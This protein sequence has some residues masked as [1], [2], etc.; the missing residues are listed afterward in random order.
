VSRKVSPLP[1]VMATIAQ[2]GAEVRDIELMRSCKNL[3]LNIIIRCDAERVTELMREMSER[4]PTATIDFDIVSETMELNPTLTGRTQLALTLMS[5]DISTTAIGGIVRILSDR[6]FLLEST[7]RLDAGSALGCI[8]MVASTQ[9]VSDAGLA[10]LRR[11]LLAEGRLHGVDVGVQ[12]E[13]ALR[14]VKRL[15]VFDMDSTLIQHEVIDE[16]AGLV[17]VKDQ[18]S[19]IT[20]EA[21]EG[22]LDFA[23]SLKRRVALLRGVRADLLE[24]LATDLHLTP[25]AKELC[26]VLKTLGYTLAV[27]SGGFTTFTHH[28]KEALG[29]DFHFANTLEVDEN[30][31]LLTGRTTGHVVTSQ[32]KA[33][34]LLVLAQQLGIR[35]E[36]VIAI[37]DGANDLPMLG[38]AGLGIAFNAKEKV[39]EKATYH[40]NQNNLLRLLFFLGIHEAEAAEL[41]SA[42]QV[43]DDVL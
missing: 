26:R 33:D 43:P 16:I 29:L 20:Q 2:F 13:S 28:V 35:K 31:G 34:L 15:V 8:E 21:M 22:K 4:L 39:R 5:S 23:E 30:T 27:I 40:I 11:E 37:G 32:R 14:G 19:R 1:D 17:G 36:E 41:I 6:G 7:R 3:I 10:A 18:V 12:R 9:T 25:G 42:T 24:K 38:L